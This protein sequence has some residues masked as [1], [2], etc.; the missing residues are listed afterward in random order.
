M[1][2]KL[3]LLPKQ[4]EFFMCEDQF[5]AFVAGVGS[6]KSRVAADWTLYGARKW[7][8]ARHFIF[9]NTFSQLRSGTMKTFFEACD[10]WGLRFIDR[11]RDKAVYLPEIGCKIEVWTRDDAELFRSL[12]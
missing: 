4:F 10:R 3:S 9:G 6:G 12:E 2:I 5:A 7:P 11:L 1:K 8:K